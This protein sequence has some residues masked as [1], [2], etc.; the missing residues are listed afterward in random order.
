M[1][2]LENLSQKLQ[3]IGFYD[4]IGLGYVNLLQLTV[5]ASAVTKYQCIS[6]ALYHT[7]TSNI[8]VLLIVVRP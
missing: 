8:I 1:E 3:S 7:F 2:Y 4:S 6:N 5:E